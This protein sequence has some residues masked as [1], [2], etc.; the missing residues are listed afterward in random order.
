MEAENYQ[1]SAIV[2]FSDGTNV[3]QARLTINFTDFFWQCGNY[4]KFCK[5]VNF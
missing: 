4:G 3:E 1:S 5:R 2:N